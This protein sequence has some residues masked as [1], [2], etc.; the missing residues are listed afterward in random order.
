MER[1][2]LDDSNIQWL[3][4]CPLPSEVRHAPLDDFD[5]L[6]LQIID[7]TLRYTLGEEN[8][9][10]IYDYLEK[11]SCPRLKIPQK[12]DAFCA[13]LR[14][15]LGHG[16]NKVHCSAEALEETIVRMVCISLARAG[17]KL[18]P[19][20]LSETRSTEFADFI[21]KLKEAYCVRNK[22]DQAMQFSKEASPV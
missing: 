5:E 9:K 7:K 13:E 18:G 2:L 16:D 21:G 3:R 20:N 8:A 4:I 6:L 19:I 14:L 10:I 17:V 22:N 11:R 15:V 1:A 12:L